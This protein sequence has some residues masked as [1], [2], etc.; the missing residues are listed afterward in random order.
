M[1]ATFKIPSPLTVNWSF[2]TVAL[3][4]IN[5]PGNLGTIIRLCDWFGINDLVCNET[6]VDCYNPK[7]VQSSVG[8]HTRVNITYLD[9]IDGKIDTKKFGLNSIKYTKLN[10]V[11]F[12]KYTEWYKI[13]T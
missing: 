4:G 13:V 7:V 10:N 2:L 8:S 1:L 6:T 5:D 12:D 3:D 11:E 9:L